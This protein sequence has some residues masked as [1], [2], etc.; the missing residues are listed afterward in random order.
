MQINIIIPWPNSKLAPNR[1]NGQHWSSTSKARAEAKLEAWTIAKQATKGYVTP[2]G[3]IA[4]QIVFVQPDK[5]RR[6]VDGL[7]SS[8]KPALDGIA[9]AIN[10]DDHYFN[11]ILITREFGAKPGCVKITIG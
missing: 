1:A 8:I 9:Q 7:L 11:S 5:R 10:I 3:Q 6:D 4:L 2:A